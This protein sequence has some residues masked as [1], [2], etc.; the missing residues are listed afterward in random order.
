MRLPRCGV[1]RFRG[2]HVLKLEF[3]HVP[4]PKLDLRFVFASVFAVFLT[5]KCATWQAT[6]YKNMLS[7][8]FRI[9][10]FCF[11]MCVACRIGFYGVFADS[12]LFAHAGLHFDLYFSSVQGWGG[13]VRGGADDVHVNADSALCFSC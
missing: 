6:L 2:R 1:E 11:P 12:R 10:F 9:V 7:P 5:E 13:G 3:W 8:P 4:H